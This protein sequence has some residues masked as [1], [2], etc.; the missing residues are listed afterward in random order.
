MTTRP[1]ENPSSGYALRIGKNLPKNAANLAYIHTDTPAPSKNV[2]VQDLTIG[3]P[4]NSLRI[5]EKE[6]ITVSVNEE[7]YLESPTGVLTL[8]RPEVLIT[9]EYSLD[10]QNEPLYYVY[11]SRYLF[12]ARRAQVSHQVGKGRASRTQLFEEFSR[13]NSDTFL[14]QGDKIQVFAA[15]TKPLD[16]KDKFKIVLKKEG[17]D[18]FTYRIYVYTNFL[19]KEEGYEL[20]YPSYLDEQNTRTKETIN[21]Q[22]IFQRQMFS[23]NTEVENQY[24]ME[25]QA[26][27]LYA[28]RFPIKEEDNI[29]V[30]ESNRPPHNFEYQIVS[31]LQTR[32]SDKNAIKVSIGI[33]Y[34]ND[35]IIN[36]VRTASALKKIVY[37]NPFM[38]EYLSFENP[39]SRNG[40]HDPADATYWETELNMPK[41]HW[42]DY[43]VL[44]VSGYGDKDFT[45]VASSMRDFMAAGGIL[46]FDNS[47]EEGSVLNP[48]SQSGKQTFIADIEF[49]KSSIEDSVRTF[50]TDAT[51]RDRYYDIQTPHKIG[52]VSPSVIFRGQE[53]SND[54]SIY[55]RH[56]NGGPSLMRKKTDS[57]GQLVVSNMGWMLDILYGK[58]ESLQFFSNFLL[59]CLEERSFVTPIFKDF[60]YHKDDLYENEY[61]NEIGQVLYVNDRSDEDASQIVAKKILDESLELYARKY[62]PE[63]YRTW[64]DADFLVTVSDSGAVPLTNPG[65]ETA[66]SQTAFESTTLKAI[67]GYDF[68]KF[69]GDS[70]FGEHSTSSAKEGVRSLRVK[71]I[72]AQAFF[73]QEIGYLQAGVYE[74]TGYV[75]SESAQGGGVAFYQP[76]G[77]FI[78]ASPDIHGTRNWQQVNILLE[79]EEATNVTLRLGAHSSNMTTD[80]YFDDFSLKTTGVVRMN[81][82]SKGGEPLYA[83]AIAPRQK[84]SQLNLYEQ[85]HNRADFI[86]KDAVQEATLTVKS[87]VY[88]WYSQEVRYKKEYGNQ[89]N[90][91]FTI[92][93]SDGEKVLGNI[94]Q[95]L[96]GLKSGAEWSKKD[97]V[98]YELSLQPNE[99]NEFINLSL[100]DPSTDQYFFTPHGE[101]IINH[102]DIWWNG[103]D[104]TVQVRAELTNYHM[105]GTGTEYTIRQQ[106][107][108]QFRVMPPGTEDERNRWYLQIQNGSFKKRSLN[109]NDKEGVSAAGRETFY[110]EYLAGEHDYQLP[111]Y[112]RQSFYPIYGQR[113]IENELAQYLDENR[114]KVQRT[115]LIIK[116]ETID[117]ERLEA[118]NA[119]RTIFN[120]RHILWDKNYLPTIY[121][122]EWQDGSTVLL[123]EGFRIDYKEGQVHFDEPMEGSILATYAYDN[124]QIVRRRHANKKVTGE[125]LRSRDNYTYEAEKE[126]LTIQPAPVLYE[127]TISEKARI[128]VDSY[129]IDYETGTFI[130]FQEKRARIYADYLY[131]VEEELTW[132][133][134]NQ[135]NGE[136]VLDKRISFKDEIYVHYLI[137]ENNLEYKGYYDSEREVFM[138]LDLN[139]TAGHTFSL[140]QESGKSEVSEVAGEKLLNKEIYLYL[141][142]YRSLYYKTVEVENNTIRHC[143]GEE[144]FNQIKATHPEALLLAIIQVREN[145]DIESVVVMDARRPGGGIKEH[146]SQESIE[147]RVG[148][149]SAFWDI[150]SFDGMAYYK[151][152]VSII[153]IPSYVL[154]EEGG[155]FSEDDIQLYV[156][157][158]MA[159][160]NYPIIEFTNET[161]EKVE[162]EAVVPVAPEEDD[163]PIEEDDGED[164]PEEPE[165]PEEPGGD[166]DE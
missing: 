49:S 48:I 128:S 163:V 67:P 36:M 105:L 54:W 118:L 44:I 9:D 116:E 147:Q 51:M 58:E 121:Y 13:E 4:E 57:I 78:T 141:L 84:N 29:L 149:T 154:E 14:Y 117:K 21:P 140:T 11:E 5:Q 18:E 68:I 46:L 76:N 32:F 80:L 85:T 74:L 92:Q 73:E 40:F 53:N 45:S 59:H 96:P 82:T 135:Y 83:Y 26:N 24:I 42:L 129:I 12:D 162:I 20:H 86:K 2:L 106:D 164:L 6:N 15:D 137:E 130:F 61:Q 31:K 52:R 95:F 153:R 16:R 30:T 119:E 150:G 77:T 60:V 144:A 93:S 87:F 88:Q 38:P 112:E 110:D 148:Y 127:G 43:D 34:I 98:Y 47:G 113:L 37:N 94:Q 64:Q 103:F 72:D 17:Q 111:E 1:H 75:R 125:L 79:L 22:A 25:Q 152:G 166:V 133:D 132:K 165:S 62:L 66:G 23:E 145:T 27:G 159:Y 151:N 81:P 7:G 104:S 136:I 90:T 131:Y 134:A 115:P 157:K 89:K 139:P 146:I 41:E 39:H 70:V 109:V 91:P 156:E 71:T 100:Y 158:Y 120:S 160:G 56:Q 102:E 99:N 28:V 35:T 19:N 155:N 138:H 108:N 33:I 10:A 122:D 8:E 55:L 124:F 3:I 143:F 114:I 123:T 65:M 97:R 101:W 142:P 161:L 50:T 63:A 107:E 69:S 126:N